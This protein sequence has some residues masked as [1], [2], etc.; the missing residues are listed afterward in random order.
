MQAV[1]ASV[2]SKLD[3]VKD[4]YVQAKA[5][6]AESIPPMIDP[7]LNDEEQSAK[8][9]GSF[10]KTDSAGATKI[11]A[12][13]TTDPVWV[14]NRGEKKL[15]TIA[16]WGSAAAMSK[17][18]VLGKPEFWWAGVLTVPGAGAGAR[19]GGLRAGGKSREIASPTDW[20]VSSSCSLLGRLP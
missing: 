15:G 6:K 8:L 11:F 20:S 4:S 17:L 14:A 16:K 9:R 5:I 7:N 12:V 1:L 2:R 13:T 3:A 19:A 18:S 10:V